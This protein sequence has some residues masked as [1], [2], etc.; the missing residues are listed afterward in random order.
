MNS[1]NDS[2]EY[3]LVQFKQGIAWKYVSVKDGTPPNAINPSWKCSCCQSIHS[4]GAT[5][6]VAHFL[7]KAGS[8]IKK[9]PSPKQEIIEELV[10][11][12]SE[13]SNNEKS[14]LYENSFF[15]REYVKD[16]HQQTTEFKQQKEYAHQS[17]ARFIYAMDLPF[18]VVRSTYFQN[19]ID[20]VFECNKCQDA[21][22]FYLP[23]ES[24]VGSVLL[25]K[26]VEHL[27]SF[28][29]KKDDLREI[30]KK[31]KQ[32]TQNKRYRKKNEDKLEDII[33][34]SSVLKTMDKRKIQKLQ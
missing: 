1:K 8:G 10:K 5:R 7:G 34:T 29:D 21:K 2:I 20:S 9:C 11:E 4:G 12:T 18:N 19:M 32:E 14:V 17:I 27:K 33:F 31:T 3:T 16:G 30:V 23:S 28:I 24:D 13:T 25:K 6:I 15:A 22:R 26:E